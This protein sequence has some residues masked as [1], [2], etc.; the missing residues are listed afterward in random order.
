MT[1]SHRRKSIK[2]VGEDLF[3]ATLFIL[4]AIVFVTIGIHD[5]SEP[6]ALLVDVN[7]YHVVPALGVI[8]IITGLAFLGYAQYIV[9]RLI[10][11]ALE[12]IF[13]QSDR[14]R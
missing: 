11:R 9:R 4:A 14:R 7:H 13:H 5:L 3:A 6:A 8:E 1:P 2:D 12:L 10:K